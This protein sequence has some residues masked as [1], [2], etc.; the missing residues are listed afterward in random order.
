MHLRALLIE[1]SATDEKLILHA[2]R[3]LVDHQRVEDDAS[4]RLALEAGGWDI[5]LCD[6]S[7]PR[8]TAMGAMGVLTE[9]GIDVPIVIVSGTIG[10][11]AA[12]EA[13]RAGA[14]DYVLKDKLGRLPAIIDREVRAQRLRKEMVKRRAE[15]ER[16]FNLSL[17]M[18]CI[19]GADGYF[20]RLNPAWQVVLGWTIT[21]LLSGPWL[22]SIHPDDRAA[23][24]E[25]GRRLWEAGEMPIEFENRYRCRD[26]TYCSLLWTAVS[27]PGQEVIYAAARDITARK[28]LEDR[29]RQSQKMEAVGNLAGG[30]A[31][32]FN[33]LLSV[34]LSYTELLLDSLKP[35]DPVR[36]DIEEVHKAGE[37]AS[38]LTRQLLAFSRQQV[39]Q[40]QIIDLNQSVVGI[41]KMIRRVLRE[42]V[43]L[44]ILPAFPVGKVRADPGQ[45]EQVILNLVVNARDAMPQG[46]NLTIEIANVDL[47][48]DYAREHPGVVPGPYVMLAVA[49]TGIGMDATT[50]ARI[51]DPFFTTKEKGEGTG[52]GLAT[53]FGIV[54]QSGGHIYVYSEPGHGS[55]FRVYLP[56]TEQV[57]SISDA[58]QAKPATLHGSETIL[59]VED[60]EQVRVITRAILRRNGYNVLDAQNG[61][62][63]LL[64]CEQYPASIHL[65]LTDV[66][67]PRMSG[68]H[69]VERLLVLRPR[70]RI[71][72]MSGYT[73]DT[74]VHHGVLEA[75]V[76]FIQKP[77]TPDTLLRKVRSVLDA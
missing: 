31:H 42:D 27:L 16:F 29:L 10:E 35:G 64:L 34:V 6:W 71:L 19:W 73:D 24:V 67:L 4:L 15:D 41:E 63:A 38:D 3:G 76:A 74:I 30:I 36:A 9:L 70:L 32:D 25:A 28:R 8:F 62:E 33:N 18:L 7:L 68:R 44:S 55:T 60:D 46:G 77:L 59:V 50:L 49:D 61:G 56:E 69:L 72:Y 17:D 58:A 22:D 1:D 39:L 75:G 53:A 47:D 66:V 40:P 45:I 20:K 51:F 65:L 13:M 26:G 12:V 48:Q 54:R 5:I 43:E 14:R 57:Q 11:E 23:T 37:R 21:E 52:L 2:L